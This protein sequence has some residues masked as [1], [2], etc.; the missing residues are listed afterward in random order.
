MCL[1]K[2]FNSLKTDFFNLFVSFFLHLLL[3]FQEGLENDDSYVYL[4]AIQCLS[5]LADIDPELVLPTILKI[6]QDPGDKNCEFILKAGEVLLKICRS[7][8]TLPNILLSL[9]FSIKFI[10]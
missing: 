5:L 4:S 6:Y 2:I 8:G 1:V 9:Y 3:P 10:S 7:L